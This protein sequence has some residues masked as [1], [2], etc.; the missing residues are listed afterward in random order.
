MDNPY[1]YRNKIHSTISTNKRNEIISGIYKEYSHDIVAIDK[2]II[3]DQK[4]DAIIATLKDLFKSFKMHP[5]NEDLRKGFIRHVLIK[6]GFKTNQTMVVLVVADK[7]FPSKNNFVKALTKKHP[8]ISTIV[9]NINS[10]KT[11]VVL[12]NDEKI[13]YGKGFIEDELLGLRF[14]ISPKAFYQVNP[15]QTEKLYEKAIEFAELKGNERV[16]DAYS[17]IGTISLIAAK[18]ARQVI[19]VEI[20]KEAVKNAK[21]NSKIND[22]RSVKFFEGDAGDFMV[23]FAESG[24][25]IDL[26]FMDP[27][28]SGSDEKFVGAIGRLSPKKIV[29]ISCNPETQLRDIR[30][31][32]G[33]GYKVRKIQPVDMFPQT[34]HVECVCLLEKK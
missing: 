22:L 12:G 34:G 19:G 17:G 13:L 32:M 8:E 25:K 27:P 30:Q 29:Y 28:R 26:L 6:T 1:N 21:I 14:Q 3:Q 16:L 11:S 23:N 15:I 2:C 9:M 31:I 4:A 10:R 24:E 18:K 33:F 20:N 5:Y 7:M